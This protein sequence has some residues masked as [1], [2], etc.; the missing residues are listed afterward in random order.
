MYSTSRNFYSKEGLKEEVLPISEPKLALNKIEQQD[1]QDELEGKYI[2]IHAR[3]PGEHLRTW[4][5]RL[6][7][8]WNEVTGENCELP[9]TLKDCQLLHHDLLQVNDEVFKFQFT[10]QNENQKNDP[11]AGPGPAIQAHR[12]KDKKSND[13]EQ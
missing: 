8:R 6:R 9:L 3:K 13:I 10:I 7:Q 5:A 4:E 11:E 12:D 1:E 2:D